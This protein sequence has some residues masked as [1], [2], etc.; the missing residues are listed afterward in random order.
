MSTEQE[1]IS[2]AAVILADAELEMSADN[3]M[4]LTDAAGLELDHIWG[5]I[6]ARA[7]EGHDLQKMLAN[8]TIPS[9]AAVGGA[10]PSGTASGAAAAAGGDEEKEDESAEEEESDDDMGMGLFD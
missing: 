1:A 5:S 7:L 10:A 8:F 4:K 6:Y 3:L 9:G 2:Y